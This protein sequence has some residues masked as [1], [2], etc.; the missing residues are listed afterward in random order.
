MPDE[1][2]AIMIHA[3][4]HVAIGTADMDAA[5]RFYRDVLGFRVKMADVE[6]DFPDMPLS[7]RKFE[8]KGTG[9]VRVIMAFHPCGGAGIELVQYRVPVLARPEVPVE[10]GDRGVVELGVEVAG[11]PEFVAQAR[12][13]GVSF[14]TDVFEE[15]GPSGGRWKVAYLTDPDGLLIQ[16]LD[17][18][19]NGSR[20]RPGSRGIHHVGIGVTE[21]EEARR[22]FADLLGFDQVF[23]EWAGTLSSR[24]G[25]TRAAWKTKVLYLERSKPS[26][27]PA[28][29]F[30][31][32][33]IKL[34]ETGHGDGKSGSR[35]KRWG[36]FGLTEIALDVSDIESVV[37]HLASGKRDAIWPP[38]R[39]GMGPG[40]WAGYALVKAPE[41]AAFIEL[42][43]IGKLVFLPPSVVAKPAFSLLKRLDGVRPISVDL[44]SV[45]TLEL[46]LES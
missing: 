28:G 36:D 2:A 6:V 29:I 33:M 18:G 13:R 34:V 26:R 27:S 39:L 5:H 41:E 45:F 25:V 23:H 44:S 10:W 21:L 38:G 24:P 12:D 42:V 3:I 20:V 17:R 11:L 37:R 32:G 43:E 31:R 40:S 4:Q 22:F 15:E 30:D 16:L 9:R 7:G 14:L 1:T 8:K 19:G 35:Q 46:D